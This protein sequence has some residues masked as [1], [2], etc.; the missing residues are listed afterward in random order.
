M[1][2]PLAN[3][4]FLSCVESNSGLHVDPEIQTRAEIESQMLE[5]RNHRGAPSSS[6]WVGTQQST[7][8]SLL[9]NLEH[10]VVTSVPPGCCLEWAREQPGCLPPAPQHRQAIGGALAGENF[11]A[12]GLSAGQAPPFRLQEPAARTLGAEGGGRP[13]FHPPLRQGPGCSRGFF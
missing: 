6:C 5:Q 3:L 9:P 2:F 1:S 12:T 13:Q 8:S 10:G 7:P 11:T 4:K